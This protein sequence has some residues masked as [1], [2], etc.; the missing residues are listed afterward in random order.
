MRLLLLLHCTGAAGARH[1]KVWE[2]QL[3]KV[4]VPKVQAAAGSAAACRAAVAPPPCCADSVAR[5][6]RVAGQSLGLRSGGPA[7]VSMAVQCRAC[8]EASAHPSKTDCKRAQPLSATDTCAAC[9]T[10][11]MTLS[12]HK[13]ISKQPCAQPRFAHFSKGPHQLQHQTFLSLDPP[14]PPPPPP[15]TISATP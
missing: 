13:L 11:K 1:V 10:L 15:T 14:P 3:T 4:A 8:P 6:Q 2:K 7:W 9:R 5:P 12:P